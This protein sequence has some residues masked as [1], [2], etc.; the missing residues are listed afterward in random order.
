[1]LFFCFS[2]GCDVLVAS[3]A[4]ASTRVTRPAAARPGVPP[5]RVFM[6][7]A[8]LELVAREEGE[9]FLRLLACLRDVSRFVG[10]S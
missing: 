3:A 8:V 4:A 2:K 6:S 10:G 7:A 9:T 1:L 5:P